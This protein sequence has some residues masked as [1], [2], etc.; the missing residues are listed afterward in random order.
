MSQSSNAVHHIGTNALPLLVKWLDYEPPKWRTRF[1][2]AI[3]RLPGPLPREAMANWILGSRALRASIAPIGFQFL[4][5]E[6]AP[7]VPALAQLVGDCRSPARA[8]GALAALMLIGKDGLPPLLS[9]VTNQVVPTP[10][11]C[12]AA[13]YIGVQARQLGTNALC[14][15]PTLVQG[16]DDTPATF[17]TAK[18][19]AKLGLAPEEVV[20]ALVRCLRSTNS[21]AWAGAAQALGEFRSEAESA[22]PDLLVAASDNDQ[23]VRSLAAGA[24]R[25]I[26]PQVLTN[27]V[28]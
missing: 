22:V 12:K 10:Y 24:V 3:V 8:D 9:V 6:A 18:V 25:R 11:R 13:D 26:A 5:Q 19:L 2:N 16:L 1:A 17:C 7:A 4:G 27:A 15:V 21:W 23:L 28:H 14:V 20:P